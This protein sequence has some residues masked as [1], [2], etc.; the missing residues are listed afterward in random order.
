M[1]K[2]MEIEEVN[3]FAE[4]I[5]NHRQDCII[6][7]WELVLD[8]TMPYNG[9][10]LDQL[11]SCSYCGKACIEIKCPYSINY[12]ETNEQNLEYLY[13]DG[14]TVKSKKNHKYFTQCIRQMG[15]GKNQKCLLCGLGCTWSGDRQYYFWQRTMG[16]NE[17]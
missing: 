17:K 1:E 12:T 15:G 13:K 11:M 16:I 10:S 6:S 2:N 8:K 3:T 9:A 5:K 7:E 4:Y 14:D